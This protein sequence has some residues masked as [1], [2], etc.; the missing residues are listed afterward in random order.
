MTPCAWRVQSPGET[1]IGRLDMAQSLG[2]Q[3]RDVL[4]ALGRRKHFLEELT[5]GLSSDEVRLVEEGE[6]TAR[7][8]MVVRE[9]A[10]SSTQ[11]PGQKDSV[12]QSRPGEGQG[13]GQRANGQSTCPSWIDS[14]KPFPTVLLPLLLPLLASRL[15]LA[16]D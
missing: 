14:S 15:F 6:A 13:M 9:F 4:P 3:G 7:A 16:S 1:L 8:G 11:R 12:P 10:H 5:P 2:R